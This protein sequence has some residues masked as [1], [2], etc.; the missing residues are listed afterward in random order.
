MKNNKFSSYSF[1]IAV[2]GA[3]VIFL[4]NLLQVFG[5]PFDSS[6]F[7]TIVVSLCGVLVVLG[8][9]TKEKNTEETE[10]KEDIEKNDNVLEEVEE[11]GVYDIIDLGLSEKEFD[12][13]VN[14]LIMDSPR[15]EKVEK[16]DKKIENNEDEKI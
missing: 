12:E 13:M 3:V 16:E 15:E 14:S 4:K 7:E 9:L 11:N 10:I 5:V 1:W 8:V 2:S 6:T